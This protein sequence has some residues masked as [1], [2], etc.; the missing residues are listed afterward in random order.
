MLVSITRD[1]AWG[2]GFIKNDWRL[3]GSD[4]I[5]L[6]MSFDG[7]SPWTGNATVLSPT[8]VVVP[9]A[10][11][12]QLIGLFRGA[13]RMNVT[14]QGQVFPFNLDGTSR[15]FL[16]L[17]QCVKT[18]LALERGEASPSPP[19]SPQA[20]SRPSAPLNPP[21]S[22]TPKSTASS[23]AEMELAS[24][25]IAT[26]LLLAARLPNARL[27]APADRPETLKGWGAAW[28]SDIGIGGV[29]LL[30]PSAGTDAQQIAS[31]LIADDAASCKGDFASGRS[32]ELVDNVVVTRA[33]VG[34][35]ESTGTREVKYF[36][37]QNQREGAGFIVYALA[38]AGG[39]PA[40]SNGGP[41]G[42]TAFQAAAV[43]AAYSP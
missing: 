35:K 16:E 17:I 23:G 39:K 1:L 6:N 4:R 29:K 43:R 32:S 22:Q 21:A 41:M 36:I 10:D 12:S 30:P 2:L 34:C 9:M 25:R 5:P 24:T 11:N 3:S 26:N 33:F 31:A 18:E 7:G 20:Q 40:N 15:M 14:A 28:A 13:Y 27:L 42:D 19:P 38:S 8:F 37:L